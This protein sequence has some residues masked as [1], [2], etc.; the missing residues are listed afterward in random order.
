MTL[1][2]LQSILDI[3][4]TFHQK[5]PIILQLN[6]SFCVKK[7]CGMITF[8]HLSKA[9]LAVTLQLRIVF[10]FFLTSQIR[11]VP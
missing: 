3:S 11:G 2:K 7:L 9:L 10:Y 8:D 6:F 4:R 5:L 1:R